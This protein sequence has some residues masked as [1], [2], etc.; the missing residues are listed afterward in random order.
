VPPPSP[1]PLPLPSPGAPLQGLSAT[2]LAQFNAGLANFSEVEDASKGL[3]PIF[4]GV[5][6]VA[7]HALPAPGG[8]SNLVEMRFG[9]TA[10]GIFDPLANEGGSLLQS[11]ALAGTTKEVIPADANVTAGRRTTPLYGFGLIEAIPDSAIRQ[12]AAEQASQHPQQAG[13]VCF[14]TSASDGAAHVGRFG[15][16]CQE[17]LLLDFAGDAYVNEMDVSNQLFP[18][19]NLPNQPAQSVPLANVEDQPDGNG[20]RDIDR[21]AN[22]MR[23]LAP[24]TAGHPQ[25]Q[26]R[27]AQLFQSVGCAVCHRPSYETVSALPVLNGQTVNPF[28]DFLLHDVGTGDGIVQGNAPANKVRTAPLMG[29]SLQTIFLHDGSATTLD[30]AIRRHGNQALPAEQAYTRLSAADRQSLLQFVQSL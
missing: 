17:A 26:S 4:N 28:S 27:G 25:P 21:F 15:W 20:V 22:F 13:E 19:Q 3:G 12:Y 8:S 23:F 1:S 9:H 6:C 10:N 30:A 2:Q 5:S 11:M 16:K 29:V 18:F 24:V 7:C 14:V